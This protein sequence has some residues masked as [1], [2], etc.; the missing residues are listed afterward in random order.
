MTDNHQREPLTFEALVVRVFRVLASEGQHSRST[1][2]R[3]YNAL[4]QLLALF[5]CA[6]AESVTPSDVRNGLGV[7]ERVT[8]LG[9]ARDAL[10]ALRLVYAQ[11]VLLGLVHNNP[12]AELRRPRRHRT[13]PPPRP[14]ALR[15]TA[16]MLAGA[17]RGPGALVLLCR[18]G[19]RPSEAR[20]L[21][22]ND[23]AR[24]NGLG[25]GKTHR[26]RTVYI[27]RHVREQ[28]ENWWAEGRGDDGYIFGDGRPPLA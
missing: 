24:G 27:P 2:A 7:I 22:W 28:L 19:L 14:H 5:G 17:A 1:L 4:G 16:A 26:P 10:M 25:S 6:P 20:N 11:G 23:S 18:L 15:H 21:R 3:L 13:T 8:S 9:R 12:V